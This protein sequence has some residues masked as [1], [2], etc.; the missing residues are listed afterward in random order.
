[1]KIKKFFITTEYIYDA[2]YNLPVITKTKPEDDRCIEVTIINVDASKIARTP[3]GNY[4]IVGTDITFCDSKVVIGGFDRGMVHLVLT[5]DN[6]N[7][8]ISDIPKTEVIHAGIVDKEHSSGFKAF[9]YT[10]NGNVKIDICEDTDKYVAHGVLE[11]AHEVNAPYIIGLE[12][13]S[14]I[15]SSV[16][17]RDNDLLIN[18]TYYVESYF[19]LNESLDIFPGNT[20]QMNIVEGYGDICD[21]Y[22]CTSTVYCDEIIEV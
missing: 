21:D 20:V 13:R 14:F 7:N 9:V 16:T 8:E 10:Y 6:Y 15:C 12:F 22:Y 18:E 4:I 11:K 17:I 2:Y 3:D 19:D 5:C 1:M